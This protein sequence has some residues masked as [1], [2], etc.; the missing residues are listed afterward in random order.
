MP[1]QL[2][3]VALCGRVR[4]ANGLDGR[5]RFALGG[6]STSRRCT[7]VAFSTSS[8]GSRLAVHLLEHRHARLQHFCAVNANKRYRHSGA[9]HNP[10]QQPKIENTLGRRVVEKQPLQRLERTRLQQPKHEARLQVSSLS[11]RQE[12]IEAGHHRGAQ[13]EGTGGKRRIV[14]RQK[15]KGRHR[16]EPQ[17]RKLRV[18]QHQRLGVFSTVPADKLTRFGCSSVGADQA[19]AAANA[20]AWQVAAQHRQSPKR[21]KVGSTDQGP[22]WTCAA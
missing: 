13:R 19:H 18:E 4:H 11:L 15:P 3:R 2:R 8:S 5:C 7:C 12:S 10:W 6:A 16:E 22:A 14:Q 1:T 9:R 17:F 21:L 20:Q